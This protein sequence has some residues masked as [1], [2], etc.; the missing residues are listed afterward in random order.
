[1]GRQGGG[2]GEGDVAVVVVFVICIGRYDTLFFC[3]F[4]P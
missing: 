4:C 2:V 1:M 3:L